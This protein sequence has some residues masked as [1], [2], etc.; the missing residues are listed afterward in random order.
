[1]LR[2]IWLFMLNLKPIDKVVLSSSTIYLIGNIWLSFLV[3][4]P[5]VIDLP[6]L[7]FL[8]GFQLDSAEW[9]VLLSV[10]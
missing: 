2:S 5:I 1:M 6:C 3:C 4:L 10:L 8:V 7:V 9:S